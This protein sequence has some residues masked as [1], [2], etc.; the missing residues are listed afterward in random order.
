[1][2]L[3]A[4]RRRIARQ[5]LCESL[6]LSGAA[7]CWD[8]F[9]PAGEAGLLVRQLSTSNNNVFLDLS[10][11]WRVLGFTAAVAMTTAMLFGT[12][13]AL[14]GTRVQ[15]NDALKIAGTRNRR[16]QHGSV[17]GNVL[18]VVQV[19]LSLI[20]VVAAGLFVRTFAS[21]A[22]MDL[23]FDRRAVLVASISAQRAQLEP[24]QRPEL[25]RRLL[26]AS[27]TVAG[28]STAGLSAVTPVSGNTWNNRIE[29]PR[30]P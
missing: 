14:R 8:C 17:S 4:S 26:E 6:L 11:D 20:L 12:A 23:G 19:A 30:R 28:V 13:P 16:R 21:L 2:A 7:P 10:L 15:P 18:V 29:L 22:H 3:G 24:P 9:S 27:S 25:F 5:L 1:M